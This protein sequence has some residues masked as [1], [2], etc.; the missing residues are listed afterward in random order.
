MLIKKVFKDNELVGIVA[1]P[2]DR[3]VAVTTDP[4]NKGSVQEVVDFSG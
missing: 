4:V 2:D 3:T 1:V